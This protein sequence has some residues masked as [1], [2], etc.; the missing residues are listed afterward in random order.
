MTSILLMVLAALGV[1]S[2]IDRLGDDAGLGASADGRLLLEYTVQCALP[3]GDH[4]VVRRD[5]HDVI[6]H[7]SLGLAPHWKRSPM[8][9][10]DQRWMT[11]CILARMNAFG[12]TVKLSLRADHEALRSVDP[13]ERQRYTYE[14]GAFYGNLFT[15]PPALYACSGAGGARRAPTRRLRVCTQPPRRGEA[16]NRCGMTMT[17]A[18][19]DV[20]E[21][22][23]GIYRNCRGGG[24]RHH[25]VLTVFLE[26]AR[27]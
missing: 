14:E 21:M 13:V 16:V 7:G 23:D 4:V 12:V 17:G 1:G 3:E 25:E 26:T 2:G 11:A 19:A 18:C 10:V 6:L 15:D 27:R 22:H 8:T 24:A 9:A 20:C 5:G